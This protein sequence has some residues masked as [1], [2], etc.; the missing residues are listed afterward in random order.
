M[1]L[2]AGKFQVTAI[3]AM[4]MS[5][6]RKLLL[7]ALFCFCQNSNAEKILSPR[8]GQLASK[9][10]I[11]QWDRDI[12]PDGKGLPKGKG[13]A[14]FGKKIYQKHCQSCHGF[15]GSGNS[16]DELAGAQHSLID[17]PPDKVIGTYW[18]Y[19]TTLYDFIRRSM[20]LNAPGSLTNNEL[21]AV[22]A[23]LLF[24]NNIVNENDII[25]H[26]NLAK[27]IMPNREGFIN[28]YALETK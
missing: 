20:P 12:F 24:L 25:S 13:T 16:A 26:K 22:T 6:I 9:A 3:S 17:E 18:P 27:V 11:E 19:A 10:L 21:Y 28:I 15:E 23:Y 4:F 7:I 14:T 5:S 8:L 2:L 1:P